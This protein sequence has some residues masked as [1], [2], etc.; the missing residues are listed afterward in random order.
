M[1]AQRVMLDLQGIADAGD[2]PKMFLLMDSDGLPCAP[3]A[4]TRELLIRRGFDDLPI[5]L[6]TE[7]GDAHEVTCRQ[8]T[9]AWPEPNGLSPRQEEKT[10][11]LA[12]DSRD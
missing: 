5:L 4:Q 10:E 11:T 2:S 8:L 1:R 9:G 3:T 12:A 7:G 6:P